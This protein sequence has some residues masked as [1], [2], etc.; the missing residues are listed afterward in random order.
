MSQE[1]S[2]SPRVAQTR[3]GDAIAISRRIGGDPALLHIDAVDFET[4]VAGKP[5][6]ERRARPCR[7]SWQSGRLPLKWLQQRS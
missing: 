4:Q 1:I 2:A 5:P 7:R 3:Q 6:P